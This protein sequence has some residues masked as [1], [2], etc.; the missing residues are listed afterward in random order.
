[1]ITF[2]AQSST[3]FINGTTPWT[4]SHIVGTG[5]SLIVGILRQTQLQPN[6]VSVT[7]NGVSMTLLSSYTG[8][9]DATVELLVYG[10]SNPDTGTHDISV[11]F[12]RAT[13]GSAGGISF[14]KLGDKDTETKY[15][16]SSG[17]TFSNSLTTSSD[18]E[19]VIDFLWLGASVTAQETDSGWNS[20]TN[21]IKCQYQ[22][23]TSAGS[24]TNTWTSSS[25][26]IATDIIM[27]FK[28]AVDFIPQVII[29]N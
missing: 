19:L 25:G 12:A 6:A 2:D 7:F 23:G 18:G 20:A 9:L 22:I 24:Y 17:A 21:S 13:Y 28:E 11:S 29:I 4:F 3:G 14:T 8:S 26:Y 5:A 27:S 10:L 1:M 16:V 15:S